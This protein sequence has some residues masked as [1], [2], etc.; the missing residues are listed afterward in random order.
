MPQIVTTE[1]QDNQIY[2]VNTPDKS[3]FITPLKKNDNVIVNG[4]SSIE[5][6]SVPPSSPGPRGR[7]FF[8][9]DFT[10]EQLEALTGPQG[11]IG[12]SGPQGIQGEKG[13]SGQAATIRVG[14][15]TTSQPGT[16]ASVTNSG[17]STDAVFN[18]TIPQGRTGERGSTGLQGPSG[19]DG[20]SPTVRVGNVS[21]LPAGSQATVTN[22][23]T[24]SNV[25]LNFGIPRGNDGSTGPAGVVQD[26]QTSTDGVNWTSALVGNVAKV[27]ITGGGGSVVDAPIQAIQKNGVTL[28]ISNKTVNVTVP[29]AVSQL[30]QDVSYALSSSLSAVATSGSYTD[31]TNKPTIPAAQVNSDWN[32]S[33]G[34]AQILNKPTL[35]TP[36]TAIGNTIPA[37]FAIGA[38]TAVSSQ[39]AD[40]ARV[41]ASVDLSGVQNADD[42]KAIEA[43]SGTTGLL[44]KTAANTWTLDTTSLVTPGT[45]YQGVIPAQWAEES[46]LAGTADKALS[47]TIDGLEESPGTPAYDLIAIEQLQGTSGLLKKT[48]ANTWTLDTSTYATTSQIPNVPIESISVNGTTQTITNKNVDISVPTHGQIA[49]GNNGYVTGGDVYS[50]I[51]SSSVQTIIVDAYNN[52]SQLTSYV[53][54]S[55]NIGEKRVYVFNDNGTGSTSTIHSL[56]SIKLTFNIDTNRYKNLYDIEWYCNG[57][58]S[59][60]TAQSIQAINRHYTGYLDFLSGSGSSSRNIFTIYAQASG[61]S[62]TATPYAYKVEITRMG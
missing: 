44:K 43:L 42:L 26:V 47:M 17:T 8:Y 49:Q 20:V 46:V 54:P 52:G 16:N 57:S 33:S 4:P 45:L 37:E 25:V 23:G 13:E 31:L 24:T 36:S 48:A 18:F 6:I 38:D 58:E 60:G 30:T 62:Y 22:S 28:P 10:E 50:W 39:L 7:G 5:I 19:A 61:S 3:L 29:T 15:V 34:V 51:P 53:I 9:E 27:L 32:A 11:P 12:P 14:S 1:V 40:T 35:V 21:T 59:A 55:M 41:A 56:K 2:K